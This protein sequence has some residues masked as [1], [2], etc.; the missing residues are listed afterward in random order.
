TCQ[1]DQRLHVGRVDHLRAGCLDPGTRGRAAL[2][3]GKQCP[4]DV[5]RAGYA[6]QRPEY[7][8]HVVPRT[9]QSCLGVAE[10]SVQSP[11][12]VPELQA[13]TARGTGDPSLRG[14][15]WSQLGLLLTSVFRAHWRLRSLAKSSVPF[16]FRTQPTWHLRH[17]GGAAFHPWCQQKIAHTL[18]IC[19]LRPLCFVQGV[20]V[21]VLPPTSLAS[22]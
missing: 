10:H 12:S 22:C 20:W 5:D 18:F 15:V 17:P 3:K 11:L 14:D 4:G 16:A 7:K 6:E 9:F 21:S 8:A 2:K 1:G 13:G 19:L